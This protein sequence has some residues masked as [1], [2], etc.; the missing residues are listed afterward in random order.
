MKCE[1]FMD[2]CIKVERRERFP[3]K[4]FFH[5][6]CCKKCRDNV[7]LISGATHFYNNKIM[8][9]ADKT[10]A[11]YLKTMQN[12]YVLENIGVPKKKVAKKSIFSFLVFLMWCVI[13]MLSLFTY[14][15]LPSTNFGMPCVEVFGPYFKLQ[16]FVI[17]SLFCTSYTIIFIARNLDFISKTLRLPK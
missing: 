1:Q 7:R 8:K 3:V 10:N 16:F 6:L 13:G 15:F 2:E 17:L 14:V 9:C 4:M 5:V 11:L 12:I